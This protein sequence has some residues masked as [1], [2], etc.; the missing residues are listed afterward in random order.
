MTKE[1]TKEMLQELSMLFIKAF[2]APPWNDQWTVETA[3][4]RLLDFINTPGF[5]GLAEYEDKTLVGMILGRSEQY[6]NGVSFQI[7]EFCVD[8][9]KQ[10]RGIGKN[11][12]NTMLNKLKEQDVQTVFL[13]TL[14]GQSTEGFYEKNGFKTDEAMIMMTK[15]LDK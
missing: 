6:Y 2:N 14:R 11:L 8:N 9:T 12:L 3:S 1:I 5:Y 13:L 7:L 15:Q 10:G 4:K